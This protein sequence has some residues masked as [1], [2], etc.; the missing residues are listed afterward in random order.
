MKLHAPSVRR[1]V[2]AVALLTAAGLVAWMFR[3]VPLNVEIAQIKRGPFERTVDEEA[4]TR[5][6]DR[7]VVSAPLAGRLLRVTRKPGDAVAANEPVANLLPA[8]PALLDARTEQELTERVGA[9]EA[10]LTAASAAVERAGTAAVLSKSELERIRGLAERGFA[11]KQAEERVVREAQLRDKDLA[12]AQNERHAVEHDLAV[13]RAAL[14]HVRQPG[15]GAAA[16]PFVVRAPEAG[17]VLRV[18]Q[19]SEAVV[20][21]GTPLL[22]IGDPAALEVVADVLTTEAESIRRGNPVVLERGRG[23]PLEGRV[24][25]VEPGAFTKVSTLGVEE[26]RTHVVID[27]TS[28]RAA[29][30]ELGDAYR[31]DA[32]IVVE[33]EDAVLTVPTAA[34]FRDGDGWAV[35]AVADGRTQR[36][37]VDIGGRNRQQAMVKRGLA[38]GDVVILYPAGS[39]HDGVRVRRST[40][41]TAVNTGPARPN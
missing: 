9:A 35:F 36:R 10:R 12:V 8:Y 28:P 31:L 40:A 37:A 39:V 1:L 29:W 17:R 15:G 4:R 19:E 13:A 18:L 34:L 26:Q 33:R 24:R 14:A 21:V 30:T 20:N 6:R 3:P 25:V 2:A 22:E 27:L 23:P 41:L 5:V 32:H 7:Y 38:E 11:S 16:S